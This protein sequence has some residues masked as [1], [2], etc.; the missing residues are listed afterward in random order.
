[1]HRDLRA[2]EDVAASVTMNYLAIVLQDKGDFAGAEEMLRHALAIRKR[3]LGEQHPDV[4]TNL[5]DLASL[6]YAQRKFDE[7][8]PLFREALAMSR[9]AWGEEDVL[10]A[11]SLN[12]LGALLY[13][14]DKLDEAEDKQAPKPPGRASIRKRDSREVVPIDQ[15]D[16]NEV[17]GTIREVFAGNGACDRHRACGSAGAGHHAGDTE[18][19]QRDPRPLHPGELLAEHDPREKRHQHVEAGAEHGYPTPSFSFEMT[20]IQIA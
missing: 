2:A 8:E 5:N 14:Q 18:R 3:L 6:L 17:L 19:D 4:A 10:V 9:K 20:I 15:T 1:M 13:Q 16:R 11:S 7:A 12:G